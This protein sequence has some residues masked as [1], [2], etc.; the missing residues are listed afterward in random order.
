M[1]T[2]LLRGRSHKLGMS[3][4]VADTDDD[5][6]DDTDDDVDDDDDDDNGPGKQN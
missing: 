4:G 1:A 5:V 6:D 3:F 2:R